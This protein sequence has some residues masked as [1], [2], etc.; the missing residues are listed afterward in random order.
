MRRK[1]SRTID[2]RDYVDP[3]AP[4]RQQTN[5]CDYNGD[6]LRCFAITGEMCR[7]AS[8]AEKIKGVGL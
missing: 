3:T 1:P 2:W 6:C 5:I 8:L 4:C 7:A